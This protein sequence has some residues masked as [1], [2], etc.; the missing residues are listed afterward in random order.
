MSRS[1]SFTVKNPPILFKMSMWMIP[2]FLSI[3][4][5]QAITTLQM[6]LALLLTITILFVIPCAIVALWGKRYCVK[7][8]GRSITLQRALQIKPV[9]FDVS[10]IAKVLCVIAETRA[11]Q[12]TKITVYTS[13]NGKFTVETLMSNSGEMKEYLEEYV[14]STIETVHKRIGV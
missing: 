3:W 6:H 4:V 12:N 11:G 2:V 7:V 14:G 1:K 5:I 8:N 9:C 13:S 10:E